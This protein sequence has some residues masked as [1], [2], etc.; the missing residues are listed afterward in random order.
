[1]KLTLKNTVLMNEVL[2]SKKFIQITKGNCGGQSIDIEDE[3]C[4]SYIYKKE[5]DRDNDFEILSLYLETHNN[6]Y[7]CTQA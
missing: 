7:L 6:K 5:V 3:D 1:M 2:N 4:S